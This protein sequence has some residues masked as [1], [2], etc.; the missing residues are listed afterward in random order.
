MSKHL[1][2]LFWKA[3]Y[4][5]KCII[6]VPVSDL[7]VI[8]RVEVNVTSDW[9]ARGWFITAERLFTRTLKHTGGSVVDLSPA[10]ASR[11]VLLLLLFRQIQ[12]SRSDL[13]NWCWLLL[14][15]SSS[16]IWK[17]VIKF[18]SWALIYIKNERWWKQELDDLW[19]RRGNKHLKCV[20][21]HG[22]TNKSETKDINLT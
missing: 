12:V 21:K 13:T 6:L 5:M 9:T 18:S 16:F 3:P 1:V 20:N 7:M 10:V 8:R 17:S 15:L 19:H 4:N 2:T 22:G 14:C 11:L